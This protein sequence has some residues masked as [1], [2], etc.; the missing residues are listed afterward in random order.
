[1]IMWVLLKIMKPLDI[2]IIVI[3]FVM[4]NQLIYVNGIL[5]KVGSFIV[6]K[7][8]KEWNFTIEI[9]V[10]N[11]EDMIDAYEIFACILKVLRDNNYPFSVYSF[12][13]TLI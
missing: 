2:L 12:K 11:S 1:M 6:N 5:K 3:G 13:L 7:C 10:E 4:I 8:P 9:Y